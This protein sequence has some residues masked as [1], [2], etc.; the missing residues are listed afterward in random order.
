MKIKEIVKAY[1]TL[2]EAN[3]SMLEESEI[4][5]IISARS[6][7]RQHVEKYDAYM[8]DVKDKFKP[9]GYDQVLIKA[10]KWHD[11]S[12]DEKI[13]INK[14]VKEYETRVN[15]AMAEL[16]NKEVDINIEKLEK[17]SAVKILKYNNWLPNK[18]DEIAIML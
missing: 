5:K 11:L 14:I 16:N 18:L 12:D 10:Q 8:Q 7:M 4:I 13:E 15:N 17:G 1:K 3:I 2:G 6:D 9:E